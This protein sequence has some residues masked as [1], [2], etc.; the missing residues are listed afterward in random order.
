MYRNEL[1]KV[2]FV[3]DAIYSDIRELAKRDISDKILKDRACKVARNCKYDG[4]QRLL[5]SMVHKFFV[6]KK[7]KEECMWDL[8]TILGQQI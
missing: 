6:Q 2:C 3:H 4:Y 7:K 8:K 1:E 5:T